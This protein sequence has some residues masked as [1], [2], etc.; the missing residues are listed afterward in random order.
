M[1]NNITGVIEYFIVDK[2]IFMRVLDKYFFLRLDGSTRPTKTTKEVFYKHKEE[3]EDDIQA[4]GYE[5]GF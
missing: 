4:F 5:E 3:I 1:A 2:G